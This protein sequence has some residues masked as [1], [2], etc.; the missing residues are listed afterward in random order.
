MTLSNAHERHLAEHHCERQIRRFALL[1]DAGHYEE[2]VSLFTL[3]GSFARPSDPEHP[4]KGRESILKS[5]QNRPRRLTRHVVSNVVVDLVNPNE[6]HAISYIVLYRGT[7][8]AFSGPAQMAPLVGGFRDNLVRVDDTWLFK[9]R[10]GSLVNWDD[11]A[12]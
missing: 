1:S 11:G 5:F 12:V 4:I 7:T 2:L 6:A 10:R 3:D 9:S 8:G